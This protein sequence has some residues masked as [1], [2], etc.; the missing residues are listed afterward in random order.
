MQ[1][2]PENS[3]YP[4]TL[5]NTYPSLIAKGNLQF[6]ST[7]KLAIFGSIKCS[8]SLILQ[9]HDLAQQLRQLDLTI[10][11]G[12][13][14][15]IE[16]E[17]LKVIIRGKMPI[18][19]CPARAI[20]NMRLRI[21]YQQLL[22]QERLL[23]LS[24]FTKER[25]MTKKTALLRNQLIAEIADKILIL[26]ATPA[27]NLERFVYE[28]ISQKKTVYT[29]DNEANQYLIDNGVVAVNEFLRIFQKKRR[30]KI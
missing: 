21:E 3:Y 5:K 19:V 1:I 29:L 18:I 17:C 26:H 23:L 8:G 15:P 4:T 24:P 25:R 30:L 2:T 20:E 11:S 13:H 28:L 9:T 10:I 16:Q 22:K 7:K 27:G 14:S 6:L 12:F